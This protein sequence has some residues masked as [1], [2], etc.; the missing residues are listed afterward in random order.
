MTG[1]VLQFKQPPVDPRWPIAKQYLDEEKYADAL[2]VFE[3][4]ASDGFVGSYYYVGSLYE[5]G[6]GLVSPDMER[7]RYWYMRAIDAIDDE[8]YIGMA[9]LALNG[10]KDAGSCSDAV[11]YLWKACNKDNP[12]AMTLLG[13]LYQYGKGV[14]RDLSQAAKLYEGAMA[15]GYILPMRYLSTLKFDE[16]AYVSGI[17]LRL[18]MILRSCFIVIKDAK[19]ERLWNYM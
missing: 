8:A 15:Y 17:W 12:R 3:D 1:K 19:D 2:K 13:T 7:A 4:L 10:Y 18:K 5:S 9:R 16:G 14:D 11:D 6:N